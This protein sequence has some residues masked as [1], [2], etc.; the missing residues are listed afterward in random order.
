[1]AEEFIINSNAIE[2]KINQLL[3]S[4]GGFGAGVDFSAITRDFDFNVFL[5]AG[6]SL[7]ATSNSTSANISGVTRQIADISGNLVDP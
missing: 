5:K 6:D 7:R 3:P 1:M 2:T 4:Q